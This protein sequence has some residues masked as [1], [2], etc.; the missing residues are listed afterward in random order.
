MN[1]E[2]V[3][4]SIIQLSFVLFVGWFF[5][6]LLEIIIIVPCFFYFRSKFEK[7]Y[8]A[9][10]GWRC[11]LY[12]MVIFTIVSAISSNISISIMLI[13]ILA[14]FINLISYYVRD[15]LDIKY[16]KK[17]KKNTNRRAIVE[18]LGEDLSEESVERV[19]VANAIP[20]LSETIY[21]FLNNTLE[22]TAD[23]LNVDTSTVTRRIN[24]FIK[25]CKNEKVI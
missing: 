15:Y 12:T 20:Q 5:E 2:V 10:D 21:L 16:P 1:W 7:Q 13:V 9:S 6:R 23:I 8:H 22:D 3:L 17:K 11:T 14:Y 18:I 25:T 19:C 4:I 24:K